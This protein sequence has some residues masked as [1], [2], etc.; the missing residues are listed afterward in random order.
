MLLNCG[1]E[2][3]LESPLH[4]TEIKPV[5]PKGNKLLVFIGKTDAEA[6]TLIIWPPDA[7]NWLTGKDPDAGKGWGQE[8]KG[9]TE[10]EMAGWHHWLRIW[11]NSGRKWRT[12]KPAV[13]Q[14]LGSQRLHWSRLSDGRTT[15]GEPWL[16]IRGVRITLGTRKSQLQSGA[17]RSQAEGKNREGI[18]KPG[19]GPRETEVQV[20]EESAWPL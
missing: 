7:K 9:R 20:S 19:G 16:T 17:S 5:N 12:G 11:A 8:E 10:D 1:V 18:W 3:T 14:S 15:R 13:L 2:K 4:Y 6:E